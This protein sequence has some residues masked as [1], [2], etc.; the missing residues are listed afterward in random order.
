[1]QHHAHLSELFAFSARIGYNDNGDKMQNYKLTL[2][3][4]GSRYKGWQK[5]G[6][7]PDTIQAKLENILSRMLSQEIEVHGSG[8]TDAGVHARA[9]VCS[10]KAEADMD[11][12]IM[13]TKLREY[14]PEDIGAVSLEKAD[15]RFHARLSCR[16]KSYVYR[17]WNSDAPN[18]FER[19]YMYRFLQKLDIAA[20][21][22][23]A[24]QLLGEHDFTAF[25]THRGN[26]SSVR[27]LKDIKIESLG[28]ELRFTF[29][30]DGFLYN[31]V[32]ILTGTLLDVGTHKL[33]PD[34]I[35]AIF[36]SRSRQNA[37]FTAPAQGLILWDVKY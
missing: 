3:Y 13:L 19:R 36:A 37:G 26:K 1:M 27:K 35:P 21:E 23:A 16:E 15:A 30:G 5:Q 18:V 10:F 14:L 32:R 6:N 33:S 12:H 7:T 4:D 20:M 34:D 29:T 11:V 28:D 24:Q 31:M 22:N 25:S 17:I 9:Q 2:S 8:R